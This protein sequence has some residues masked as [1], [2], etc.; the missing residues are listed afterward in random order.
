VEYIPF[1]WQ[2][3]SRFGRPAMGE[4]DSVFRRFHS[5]IPERLAQLQ[6]LVGPHGIGL[7]FSGGSIDA[8]QNW[9][10]AQIAKHGSLVRLELGSEERAAL[11]AALERELGHPL[12]EGDWIFESACEEESTLPDGVSTGIAEDVGIYLA[13]C[14]LRHCSGVYWA[15]QPGGG[16]LDGL[17]AN[18]SI[19]SAVGPVL[20]G[21]KEGPSTPLGRADFISSMRKYVAQLLHG[22]GRPAGCL[23]GWVNAVLPWA[24]RP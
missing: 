13:E 6:R 9:F 3:R 14:V 10:E 24:A 2:R 5:A 19:W 21:F 1:D 7:D 16:L 12:Q 4:A 8:L 11:K 18:C 20:E 17:G 22:A 15:A 23:R